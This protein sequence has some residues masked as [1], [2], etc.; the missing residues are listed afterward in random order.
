MCSRAL[1]PLQR[2]FESGH[3]LRLE[4]EY[5]VYDLSRLLTGPGLE[6]DTELRQINTKGRIG[7]CFV[8]C[9]TQGGDP[10]VPGATTYG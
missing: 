7:E 4:R 10:V 9:V 2:L 8:K 1:F 5:L 3:C 6:G